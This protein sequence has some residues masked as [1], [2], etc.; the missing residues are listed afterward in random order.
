VTYGHTRKRKSVGTADNRAVLAY[1]P[2]REYAKRLLNGI[3]RPKP[4]R[5]IFP[6]VDE[7]VRGISAK[8]GSATISCEGIYVLVRY[9]RGKKKIKKN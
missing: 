7:T 4:L 1:T 8:C 2:I 3:I 6:A 5:H 9:R